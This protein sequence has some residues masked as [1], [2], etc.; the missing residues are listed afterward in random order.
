MRME[1]VKKRRVDLVPGRN[2][3]I[4]QDGSDTRPINKMLPVTLSLIRKIKG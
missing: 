1:E 2:A 3:D 4:D